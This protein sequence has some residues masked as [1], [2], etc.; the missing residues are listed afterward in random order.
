MSKKHKALQASFSKPCI[1]CRQEFSPDGAFNIERQLTCEDPKCQRALKT[2][3]QT[4]RRIAAS[5]KRQ[6][7]AK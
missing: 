3:R 6:K 1:V 2:M 4:G 5:R 7:G